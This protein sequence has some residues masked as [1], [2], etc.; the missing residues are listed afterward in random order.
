MKARKLWP[1]CITV[2]AFIGLVGGFVLLH[3]WQFPYGQK[4]GALPLVLLALREYGIEHDGWFPHDGQTPLQSLQ[5]LYPKYIDPPRYLAGLTGDADGTM[6]A[7][8]EGRPLDEKVSSW[9]YWPGFKE[10]DRFDV[11]SA[12]QSGG[13]RAEY[14]SHSGLVAV[15]WER[16]AG[17]Q[18]NGKRGKGRAVGFSDG[19][20]GQVSEEEWPSFLKQQEELRQAVMARRQQHSGATTENSRILGVAEPENMVTKATNRGEG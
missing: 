13:P 17:I 18:L 9:I 4:V 1:I 20:S 8:Q 14:T 16:Q 5:A 19:S 10:D 6:K 11:A 2:V 7:L 15:I 3:R 12:V